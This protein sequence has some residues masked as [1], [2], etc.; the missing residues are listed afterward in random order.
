M[1]IRELARWTRSDRSH[2]AVVDRMSDNYRAGFAKHDAMD[3]ALLVCGFG[4]M[5]NNLRLPVTTVSSMT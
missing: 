4:G 2:P 1:R 3:H 5:L